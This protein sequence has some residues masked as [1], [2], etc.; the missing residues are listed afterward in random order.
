MQKLYELFLINDG[1]ELYIITNKNK[2][3]YDTSILEIIQVFDDKTML[4]KFSNGEEKTI[5]PI[6]DYEHIKP[7][8]KW[9][10]FWK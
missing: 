10:Q 1:T 6:E 9:Y 8:N 2:K 4:V 3:L 5:N 7:K